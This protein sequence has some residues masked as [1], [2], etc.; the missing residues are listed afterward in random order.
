MASGYKLCNSDVFTPIYQGPSSG[1][2][3][4]WSLRPINVRWRAFS[5]SLPFYTE[6]S[7]DIDGKTVVVWGLPTPYVQFEV[8]PAEDGILLMGS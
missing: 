4:V 6:G 1:F 8:K 2:V 3:Y 7:A 5:V